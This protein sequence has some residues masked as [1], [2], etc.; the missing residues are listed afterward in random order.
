MNI[1]IAAFQYAVE[2][3]D[4]LISACLRHL[5]LVAIPLLIGII[6]GLPLGLASS[7]N[8]QLSA[9]IINSFNGL[10]VI[11]SLAILFLAIPYFGLTFTAAAIAI[12]LLVI[13][14]ILIN[15]DVAFRS[16]SPEIVEA[17][18]GMGMSPG[19]ILTQVEIPLALPIIIGGIKTAVVEGIASATLAAFIGVGGLGDFIVLGFALYDNSILLVGAIPVAIFALTAEISLSFLQHL[20]QASPA[21]K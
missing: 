12:T 16:I 9:I 15:T 6:I 2:N 19:Q 18:K 11:P 21:T 1:F 14:P 4:K 17:A 5:E 10:R 20:L 13:P 7:R 3:S 8:R